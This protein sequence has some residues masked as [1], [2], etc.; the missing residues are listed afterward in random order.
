MHVVCSEH[1]LLVHTVSGKFS[2]LFQLL[3]YMHLVVSNLT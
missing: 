3:Y 2:T 1:D